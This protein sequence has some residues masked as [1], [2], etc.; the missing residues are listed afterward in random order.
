[1]IEAKFCVG[2]WNSNAECSGGK[3]F[4]TRILSH[5]ACWICMPS[6]TLNTSSCIFSLVPDLYYHT[7][8]DM[9]LMVVVLGGGSFGTAMA[10]HM[11]VRDPQIC[12]SINEKHFNG[13]YFPDHKLPDNI[14]ATAD[15]KTAFTG[16]DYCLHAVPVQ[17]FFNHRR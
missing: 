9:V 17:A 1:M 2:P 5:R 7:S 4:P 3:K 14:I 16:A 6:L 15:A 8:L 12:Q 13:K 11:R 10:S